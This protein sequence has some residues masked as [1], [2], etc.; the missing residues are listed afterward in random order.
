MFAAALGKYVVPAV[1][2][3]VVG[4]RWTVRFYTKKKY[5]KKYPNTLGVCLGWKREIR[6]PV[7]PL[8]PETI[9]HELT[10]AYFREL[11]F[12][13]PDALKRPE[14]EEVFCELVAQF[15]VDLLIQ[16]DKIWTYY[17]EQCR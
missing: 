14:L 3:K 2:F 11:C 5:Q 1:K 15:G 13:D 17:Q 8:R 4:K 10:H 12:V 6:L 7:K 9:V 16:A